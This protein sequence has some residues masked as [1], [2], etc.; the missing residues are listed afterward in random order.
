MN[1]KE[2]TKIYEELEENDDYGEETDEFEFMNVFLCYYKQLFHTDPKENMFSNIEYYKEISTSRSMEFLYSEMTKYKNFASI[3]DEEKIVLYE[4]GELN[5]D[6]C[7]ELY[8]LMIDDKEVFVC[9]TLL[10]LIKYVA[11]LDWLNIK[12]SINPLKTEYNEE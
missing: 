2:D 1:T 10:P 12:W 8:L 4:P 6:E 11:T 3:E 7:F 5:I 9:Q